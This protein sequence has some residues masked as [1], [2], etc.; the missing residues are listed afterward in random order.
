LGWLRN[1]DWGEFGLGGRPH[2]TS[3]DPLRPRAFRVEPPAWRREDPRVGVSGAGCCRSWC[4]GEVGLAPARAVRPSPRTSEWTLRAR[5]GVMGGAISGR[6]ER[7]VAAMTMATI[8]A[9]GLRR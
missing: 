4:G 5:S 9:A 7:R 6:L 8:V 3:G 1:S 2:R